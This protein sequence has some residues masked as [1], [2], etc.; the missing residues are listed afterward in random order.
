VLR[1][2]P[3]EAVDALVGAVGADSG[4]ELMHVE[5]RHLEGALGREAAVPPLHLVGGAPAALRRVARRA[6]AWMP[7]AMGADALATGWAQVRD[8]ADQAGREGALGVSLRTNVIYTPQLYTG[9]DRQPFQGNV[10]QI[11]A[12]VV[13]HCKAAPV[14]DVLLDLTATLHDAQE[15][16]DVA[17]ELHIALRRAGI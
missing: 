8:F 10:E 5:L 11:V 14:T 6:D 4:C 15:M 13:D 17:E 9:D 12:D 16:M 2:L 7:V 1:E 3:A